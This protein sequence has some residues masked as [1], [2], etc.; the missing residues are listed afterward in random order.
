MDVSKIDLAR[1]SYFINEVPDTYTDIAVTTSVAANS[2][3]ALGLVGKRVKLLALLGPITYLAGDHSSAPSALTVGAG[4]VLAQ[5]AYS[6]W[7]FVSKQTEILTAIGAGSYTL[8][9]FYRAD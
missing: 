3:A 5:N 8:R 9:V 6:D 7:Y 2:L 1:T 4:L